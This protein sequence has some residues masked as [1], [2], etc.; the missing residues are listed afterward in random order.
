MPK[1]RYAGNT[2]RFGSMTIKDLK[3]IAKTMGIPKLSQ[4]KTA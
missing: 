3:Q 1:L 2:H 4:Y